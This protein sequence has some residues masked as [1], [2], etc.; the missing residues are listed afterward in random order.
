M[1]TRV[2]DAV[3]LTQRTNCSRFFRS[4]HNLSICYVILVLLFTHVR[5]RVYKMYPIHVSIYRYNPPP[6]VPA[7]RHLMYDCL[8][9]TDT[10]TVYIIVEPKNSLSVKM[11]R[12]FAKQEF[13]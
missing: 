6:L 5:D 3:M 1:N 4:L 11:V 12:K 7:V 13:T 10:Q 9:L 8:P 2:N